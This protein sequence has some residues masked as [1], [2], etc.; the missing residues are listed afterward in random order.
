MKRDQAPWGTTYEEPTPLTERVNTS[1]FD[2]HNVFDAFGQGL[3]ATGTDLD[4]LA[5]V[6][7]M[8]RKPDEDDQ[9]F[10]ERI[11]HAIRGRSRSGRI[12]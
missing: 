3:K 8:E 12:R 9:E 10:R 6:C 4:R 7:G 5:M 11:N 1:S 2:D